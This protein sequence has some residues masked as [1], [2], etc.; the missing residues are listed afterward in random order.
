MYWLRGNT[1]TK[2][3]LQKKD[4]KDLARARIL[5]HAKSLGDDLIFTTGK[6]NWMI[7]CS[8]YGTL[9]AF[10]W[11]AIRYGDICVDSEDNAQASIRECGEDWLVLFGVK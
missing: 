3:E 8:S 6:N 7:C 5:R 2:E 1:G 4:R 9:R 10:W 11:T